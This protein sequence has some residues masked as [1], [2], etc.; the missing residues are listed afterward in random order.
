MSAPDQTLPPLPEPR[1]SPSPYLMNTLQGGGIPGEVVGGV[2]MVGSHSIADLSSPISG[3]H[4]GGG[5]VRSVL[6]NTMVLRDGIPWLALGSPGN[7]HCTVPQVLSNILDYGMEPYDADDAPRCLPYQDDHTISVES[8]VGP[9]VARDL[10][11]LG[12]LMNPLPA[13][14]YHMGT[15]QTSW[16]AAD[17]TLSTC[18]GPRRE[19]KAAG[20]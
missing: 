1:R 7:V 16:R 3:W 6:S 2:P 17:G 12:V 10:A 11:R 5:R 20:A 19:G 8:R 14:D 13:Y 9:D 18:T 15:Y 4:A